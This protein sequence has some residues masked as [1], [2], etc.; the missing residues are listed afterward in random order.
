MHTPRSAKTAESARVE[1]TKQLWTLG[2]AGLVLLFLGLV[3]AVADKPTTPDGS[4]QGYYLGC[5]LA[6]IGAAMLIVVLVALG[7]V[8]GRRLDPH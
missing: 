7:T 1:A 3:V 4:A 5:V 2:C 8:I 6:G